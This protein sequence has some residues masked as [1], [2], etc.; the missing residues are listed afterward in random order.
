MSYISHINS[1][2][3]MNLREYRAQFGSQEEIKQYNCRYRTG[4]GRAGQGRAGQDRTGQDR[5]GQDRTGQDG[6]GRDK[7]WTYFYIFLLTRPFFETLSAWLYRGVILDP[8][9][10]FFVEDNQ[11]L[12]KESLPLEYNDDFW[13]KRYGLRIDKIPTFLQEN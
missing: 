2:H 7:D 13:E 9:K 6:T 12:C 11:V 5:T 8:S 10:D 1:K 4:K 3:G